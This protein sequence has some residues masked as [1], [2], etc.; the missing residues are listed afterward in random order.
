MI[1]PTQ[2]SNTKV[3][4]KENALVHYPGIYGIRDYPRL[5]T[6]LM[7]VA[8]RDETKMNVPS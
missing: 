7:K 6:A 8:L 4:V 2:T 3:K 1:I 5:K